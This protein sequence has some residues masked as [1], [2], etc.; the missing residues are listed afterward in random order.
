MGIIGMVQIS[1]VQENL[2]PLEK[3]KEEMETKILCLMMENFIFIVGW[4]A[5]GSLL[6]VQVILFMYT[7]LFT[8]FME[9]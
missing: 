3:K 6:A 9:C 1:Y 8:C 5:F 7:D 4:G 2:F